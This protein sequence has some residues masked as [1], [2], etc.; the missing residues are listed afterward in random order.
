MSRDPGHHLAHN[1]NLARDRGHLHLAKE[2]PPLVSEQPP[3][4]SKE[5]VPTTDQLMALAM[6]EFLQCWGRLELLIIQI[7][8]II[9]SIIGNLE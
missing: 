9:L 7:A 4:V 1:H 2:K 3:L 5:L 6:L 8:P